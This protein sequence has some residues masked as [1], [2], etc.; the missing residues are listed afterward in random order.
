MTTIETK[1]VNVVYLGITEKG[2]M[3]FRFESMGEISPAYEVPWEQS[4]RLI[5]EISNMTEK[6]WKE[7]HQ[8]CMIVPLTAIEGMDYHKDRVPWKWWVEREP[9]PLKKHEGDID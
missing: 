9:M 8:S 3:L 5:P 6:W 2:N 7:N 1:K 4:R